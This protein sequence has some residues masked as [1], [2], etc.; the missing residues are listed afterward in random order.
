MTIS[1]GSPAPAV[2]ALDV[3]D[4]RTQVFTDEGIVRAVD[5]V[6]FTVGAG[7]TLGIV[8]ESGSG[9][10]ITAL[11]LM[12]LLEEPS[13]VVGGEVRFQGRDLLKAS[14]D[15]LRSLRGDRL[16]MVF[17]NPMTSLN[18]VLKIA[19]QLVETMVVHGR[20]SPEQAGQRAV[21]LLGR[22]GVSAPERAV[23]SYP[24]QFSGGM[25]QRVM[26]A[27]GMSNEPSLLIADEPTTA[28]DVTIQAQILELLRELNQDFGTAIVLI[29]HDLGVIARVCSRTI[30]MYGGEVVEDGPTE[31]LL[32]DPRHPYTWALINA[33]PRMD[34]AAS[35]S[36]RLTTIDGQPPDPL[37]HPPGCRFAERCPFRVAQCDVHPE[38]AE[39]LPERKARCWV[40]QRGAAL[41]PR[42]RAE[43]AAVVSAER[44]EPVA[45]AEAAPI[46]QVRGLVKRFAL[47]RR[48]FFEA[49]RFVHAVDHVDLDVRRGE[50]VGLVGESGCGKSTLARNVIR[51]HTPDAGDILFD[52]QNIAR[53]SQKEIRPLR[54]R[55]Q[56]VFQDPY[57]SLNPRMSVAEIL[58]EPLR[59]HGLVSTSAEV[60]SRIDELLRTVGLNPKSAQRYP[61]EFSGGQ[62]QRISIARALAVD[63]EF[64]V[65]DEPISALDVNIQAQIINLM[66][67]LQE[68]FALTYLFIAH[69]LAVVRHISNRIVVLYLGKVMEI[70]PSD[71]IFTRPLHPYTR[72][73]ISA[74][75]I[76]DAA[77]ERA[78]RHVQLGG[79]PPS[80]I[81][82]PSG[83]RFRTRCPIAKPVCASTP[84][85]LT[86]HAAGHFAACHFPDQLN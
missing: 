61:H 71:A 37:N 74:V 5:G 25:R 84:P 38:L 35:T 57:A 12:R 63:P 76:P 52:G 23:D 45:R 31:D 29:S 49:P 41:T 17:Q 60:R 64:I 1:S 6:S 2:P 69:D 62:R 13:R 73:L 56:M 24:H 67:D 27:L 46:L 81:A 39:V 85:P 47:P 21:S 15:E 66:L 34:D 33:V 19:R 65:A 40:T 70:A 8:G 68:R 54:K 42:T 43:P 11:S 18:P 26:L 79:E 36:R 14:P 86:E 16:A 82:P 22:M 44:P 9:K 53:S 75:P 72:Y 58:G 30:V 50:T 80:A 28:L 3:R 83:C 78:R 20:Y 32:A 59:F 51:I 48:G 10:S 77:V 7:E 4:L 55:M